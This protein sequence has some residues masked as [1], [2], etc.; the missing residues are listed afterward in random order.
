M[1]ESRSV[2]EATAYRLSIQH[3]VLFDGV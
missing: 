1:G 2:E 3:A